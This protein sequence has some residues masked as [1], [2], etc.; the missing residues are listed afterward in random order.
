MQYFDIN[1][2][3]TDDFRVYY[4]LDYEIRFL[5]EVIKN[6]EVVDM[7]GDEVN[8]DGMEFTY[9]IGGYIINSLSI[10]IFGSEVPKRDFTRMI[11]TIKH[12]C[13]KNYKVVVTYTKKL[14]KHFVVPITIKIETNSQHIIAKNISKI[15]FHVKNLE[16]IYINDKEMPKREL[17]KLSQDFYELPLLG[18]YENKNGLT[19]TFNS[20]AIRSKFYI[21][22]YYGNLAIKDGVA[23]LGIK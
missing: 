7:D 17:K 5:N 20:D 18:I 15:Q 13:T 1:A 19:F 2:D 3:S 21:W 8:D 22:Y 6:I 12:K 4:S 14:C 10:N 23:C 16:E 9:N 11:L